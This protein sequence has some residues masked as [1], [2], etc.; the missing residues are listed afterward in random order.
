MLAS[1]ITIAALAVQTL[2]TVRKSH[3]LYSSIQ[4]APEK[5]QLLLDELQ[6]LGTLLAGSREIARHIDDQSVGGFLTALKY[7]KDALESVQ[8]FSTDLKNSILTA[9]P[10]LRHWVAFKAIVSN[11]TLKR[12]LNK[13]ERAK[14]ML[15][16]AHQMCIQ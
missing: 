10:G 16:L 6:L 2:E 8:A 7:C 3:E 9:R 11:K 13:L 15:S 14:S 1:V 5:L 4:D 12:H